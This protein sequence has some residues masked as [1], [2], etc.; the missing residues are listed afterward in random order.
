MRAPAHTTVGQPAPFN[1]ISAGQSSSSGVQGR[2]LRDALEGPERQIIL[3]ALRLHEWNRAAT[4]DMLQI[5]RTTLYK[6]MKRL[7]LDDPRL[8]FTDSF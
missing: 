3:E 8:Q 6:K 4:A 5:N 2:S 1:G 7:G